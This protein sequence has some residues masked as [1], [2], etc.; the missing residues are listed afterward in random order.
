MRA[1][2]F[3]LIMHDPGVVI[4]TLTAGGVLLLVAERCVAARNIVWWALAAVVLF[5]A[6][7]LSF[8]TLASPL[9]T[10]HGRGVGR[11][12]VLVWSSGLLLCLLSASREFARDDVERRGSSAGL[13]LLTIAGTLSVV[14]GVTARD[15]WMGLELIA[16]CEI[17]RRQLEPN[18]PQRSAGEQGLSG[19]TA[20]GLMAALLFAIGIALTNPSMDAGVR[21]A[22]AS[23]VSEESSRG[24][25]PGI[26]G[27]SGTPRAAVSTAF[28]IASLGMRLMAA[29]FHLPLWQLPALRSFSDL[30]A[31]MVLGRGAVVVAWARLIVLPSSSENA[32]AL[33]TG[34]TAAASLGIGSLLLAREVAVRS[35]LHAAAM[36]QTGIVLA[37]LATTGWIATQPDLPPPGGLLE[38][39][40]NA[41]LAALIAEGAVLLGLGAVSDGIRAPDRRLE[42]LEDF[43][44]LAR[45]SSMASALIAIFLAGLAGLPLTAPFWGRLLVLACAWS[46]RRDFPGAASAALHPAAVALTVLVVMGWISLI[47]YALRIVTLTF[48]RRPVCRHTLAGR[49]PLLLGALVATAIVVAGVWPS[50]LLRN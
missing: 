38:L 28:L 2:F 11:A 21:P 24:N 14:A 26:A 27:S 22:V 16:F 8:S 20:A 15:L 49:W 19:E 6:G 29:P 41:W 3:G 1:T 34:V 33:L 39:A 17:A 31:W 45:N 9:E 35:G 43:R 44:G 5:V 10:L 12:A 46:V 25:A 47:G 48:W 40:S 32:G 36:I 18:E 42:T 50:L 7:G 37:G 23:K 13:L 4:L 30:T